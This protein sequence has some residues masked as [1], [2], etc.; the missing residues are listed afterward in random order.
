MRESRL[1]FLSVLF[2]ACISGVMALDLRVMGGAGNAF[3]DPERTRTLGSG[4][5]R[6]EPSLSPFGL[7]SLEGDYS[8][9][10]DYA[11]SYDRDPV[12]R[13][14]VLANVGFDFS[15]I[16][17]E[18]GPFAGLFNTAER[19]VR[20]G[21]AAALKLE[22]P[23]IIFGSL[24][25]SSTIGSPVLFSGDF[26]Q[27]SGEVAFGFWIPHVICTFSIANKSFTER[28]NDELVTKDELNRFQFQA[29][30]FAKNVPYTVRID[31][32]YQSLKRLYSQAG[33]DFETDE[34]KSIFIGFEGTYRI[35][36]LFQ[37]FLGA[38]MPVYAWGEKPLRGP[39]RP[40][41]MYQ[42]HAGFV[43]TF[44]ASPLVP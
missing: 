44:P 21:I 3:F 8:D 35:N 9:T 20:P 25:G 31:L 14:R 42:F 12:L 4:G 36:S 22:Y 38:E 23:G 16:K 43:C 27:E 26:I 13:N 24:Q 40:I 7:L 17:L 39:E 15:F 29:D 30:V 11:A 41:V 19:V 1:I 5:N 2:F 32:G 37:L 28:K 18:F 34:L 6:F 33:S 10:V